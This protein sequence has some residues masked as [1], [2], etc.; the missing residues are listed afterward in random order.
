MGRESRQTENFLKSLLS[1]QR[2]NS[3][4]NEVEGLIPWYTISM[5]F[6]TRYPCK[7]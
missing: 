4:N 5:I 2:E 1:Y 6:P 7:L 3:A